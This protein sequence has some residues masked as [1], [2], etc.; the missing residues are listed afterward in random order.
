MLS[1]YYTLRYVVSTLDSELRGRRIGEVF[2]QRPDELVVAFEDFA[3]HLVILCRRDASI[4]YLDDRLS[5][6]KRNSVD[7]LPELPGAVISGV[8]LPGADR[9]ALL[10]LDTGLRAA[11]LCFGARANVCVLDGGGMVVSAF[12][13]G[14]HPAGASLSPSSGEVIFD[15][16]AFRERTSEAGALTVGTYVRRSFPV[17]GTT[18]AQE[19][20]ARAGI[21][22]TAH[23]AALDPPACAA[24]EEAIRSMLKDLERPLP[25]HYAGDNGVPT[26]FSLILLKQASHLTEYPYNDIHRALREFIGRREAAKSSVEAKE[27]LLFAIR[28]RVEKARRKVQ[29]LEADARAAE[30][31]SEY[32]RYAGALMANVGGLVRGV[33]SVTVEVDGAPLTI[34][35]D[36]SLTAVQNSQRYYQKAKKARAATEEA[37]RQRTSALRLLQRG[38]ALLD[39][40]GHCETRDDVQLFMKE[41][42]RELEEFGVG[43]KSAERSTLP[44]RV[45]T[46]AGGFEVWAGKSSATN[47]LLTLRYARPDDLW[48]HAR[49]SSGSHVVLRVGTGKGEP[50]KQAREEAAAIAAYYSGMKNAGMVPVA[51]TQKRY[52]RKPKGSPPG[53]VVIE[54]EKVIFAKPGLPAVHNE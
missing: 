53:S 14:R 49:G 39:A 29:A 43:R 38:E 47:D 35:V 31:A 19:A 51:M 5:R 52:V 6:A 37:T 22:P 9:V 8:T 40:I 16:V 50:G 28:Q 32:E 13:S 20:L 34:P 41:H 25:R 44:F 7:L 10:T 54:R 33:R 18:L 45:F 46:V 24:V 2:S 4:L 42:D 11:I 26:L 1:N 12:K 17:L 48:F 30:R 21:S 27:S 36:P 3:R 23:V 15:F